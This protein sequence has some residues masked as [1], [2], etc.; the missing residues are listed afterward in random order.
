MRLR[1][2]LH[3]RLLMPLHLIL[4]IRLHM[5][6]HMGWALHSN[7]GL[8][9]LLGTF[10]CVSKHV[11]ASTIRNCQTEQDLRAVC[12]QGQSMLRQFCV[13]LSITSQIRSGINYLFF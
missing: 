9:A 4:H 3:M 13:C 11:R 2:R 8:S 1:M 12:K 7:M 5:R 6:L 10:C